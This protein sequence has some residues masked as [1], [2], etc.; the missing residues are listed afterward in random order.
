[1]NPPKHFR[2]KYQRKNCKHNFLIICCCCHKC[3]CYCCCAHAVEL[4]THKIFMFFDV[5]LLPLP[6]QNKSTPITLKSCRFRIHFRKL[7][8]TK[9]ILE[10]RENYLKMFLGTFWNI[11][12]TVD[13]KDI[14]IVFLRIEFFCSEESPTDKN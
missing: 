5:C 4:F 9:A 2:R 8:R 3:C 14:K 10:K 1:M 11:F 12:E 6:N 13:F 7:A